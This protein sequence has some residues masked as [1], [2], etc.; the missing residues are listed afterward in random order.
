[1]TAL[2]PHE[3]SPADNWQLGNP[4]ERYIGRWSRLVAPPFVRWLDAPRGQRWLDVGCGTGAL[5]AAI[6]ELI[7]PAAV[8]GVD[9]SDGFLAVA[10][11]LLPATVTLLPGNATAIPL[12]DAA[13]D[14]AVSGLVLNFVADPVAALREMA[15]VSARGATIAV[16]VWDYADRMELLRYFWDAAAAIDPEAAGLDEGVRFPL[17]Q[18]EAL[19]IAAAMAGLHDA[20]VTAIDVPTVFANFEDYWTPFLGGQ[21]PAPSYVA[22]L[23]EATRAMLR[24]TLQARLPQDDTGAIHLVARAWALRATV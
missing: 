2:T 17:C 15:R 23:D 9:P 1:M 3:P 14:A 18:P 22:A 7:A 10:R 24:T 19:I 6:V 5:C 12:P 16:Y 21:G 8:T 11:S 13:V 4:Y 20:A